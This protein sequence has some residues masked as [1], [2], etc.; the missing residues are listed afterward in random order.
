MPN[1]SPLSPDQERELAEARTRA[2]KILSAA[3]V[4]TFNGWTLGIIAAFS[5]LF[6]FGSVVALVMGLGLGWIAWNEFRG[7]ARLRA[8]DPAG[9]VSLGRNQ[10]FL[11]GLI[12]AYALF[13]IYH[14][15]T[16][17][18]PDLAELE[19]VVGPVGG[20][21]RSVMVGVYG[22]VLVL[23]ALVQGLNARYYL[24]R[25]QMIERY[26][27]ETPEWVVALQRTMGT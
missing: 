24:A 5:L 23:T 2:A 25:R 21:I 6:A 17:P 16:S 18:I 8:F 3:R 27:A 9:A 13:S 19:Q 1:P 26:L 11:L 14:T 15:L 20:T 10:L 12:A 7:R 22:A 4:A